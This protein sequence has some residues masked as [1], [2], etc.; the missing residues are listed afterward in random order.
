MPRPAMLR[1]IKR[2]KAALG[3]NDK[4][5]LEAAPKYQR[6]VVAKQAHHRL[7]TRNALDGLGKQ[8]GN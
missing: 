4:A 1:L 7:T 3:K 5:Q 8:R 6:L 2:G